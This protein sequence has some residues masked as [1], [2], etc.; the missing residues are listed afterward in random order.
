MRR[1]PATAEQRPADAYRIAVSIRPPVRQ[2][3]TIA[4]IVPVTMP[5]M[6]T[7]HSA[8]PGETSIWPL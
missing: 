4:L 8:R 2:N 6:V 1:K 5:M 3:D 7:L